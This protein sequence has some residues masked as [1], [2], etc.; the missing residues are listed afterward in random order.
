MLDAKTFQKNFNKQKR[1]FPVKKYSQNKKTNDLTKAIKN[2]VKYQCGAAIWRVNVSPI[3]RT[4]WIKINGKPFEVVSGRV[5]APN[6][7]M[8]DLIAIKNGT[9]V[10]IEIKS[11]KDKLNTFQE[12]FRSSV[13]YAGGVYLV[14]RNLDEFIECWNNVGK[15]IF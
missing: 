5:P 11:E 12:D 10:A 2:Y 14:V 3:V 8:S 15:E 9:F 7:G 1:I 4:N 13:N 6:K